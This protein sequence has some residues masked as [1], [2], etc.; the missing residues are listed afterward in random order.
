MTAMTIVQ[1]NVNR[2]KLA[3]QQLRDYCD[4]I[5]A[6]VVL[7]QEPVTTEGRTWGFENCRQTTVDHDSGA[8]IVVMDPR[9]QVIELTTLSTKHIAVVKI[10]NGRETVTVVSAYFKYNMP[11]PCFVEKLRAVLEHESRALIGADVN[12]HSTLRHCPSRND[13]GRHTEELISDYDLTVANKPSSICT[14]S[15]EGMGSSNID[16]TL[17][18]PQISGMISDWKIEDVTDSDHNVVS[19]TIGSRGGPKR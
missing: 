12:G 10:G 17:L 16:V 2:Q 14:Y 8:V 5:R 7:I 9:L 1:H 4:E 13:R 19:F 6:D 3:S 15:R 11:T 18:T